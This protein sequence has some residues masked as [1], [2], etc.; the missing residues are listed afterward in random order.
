M[1][2]KTKSLTMR[3]RALRAE[4]VKKEPATT[5]FGFGIFLRK[6]MPAGV[7]P[8]SRRHSDLRKEGEE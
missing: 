4:T 7:F 3:T 6:R 2:W 1:E 8:N 5:Q